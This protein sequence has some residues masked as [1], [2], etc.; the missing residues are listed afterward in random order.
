MAGVLDIR[1]I[2]VVYDR[3][4]TFRRRI[5]RSCRLLAPVNAFW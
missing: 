2:V 5:E 1:M 3:V 4:Y